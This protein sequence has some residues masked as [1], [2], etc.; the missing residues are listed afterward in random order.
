MSDPI[1][2]EDRIYLRIPETA[3][4]A[5]ISYMAMIVETNDGVVWV[6]HSPLY[7]DAGNKS[8]GSFW[9]EVVDMGTEE[10]APVGSG[11]DGGQ[12]DPSRGE[13]NLENGTP[14]EGGTAEHHL[15]FYND[16]E[17]SEFLVRYTIN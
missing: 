1:E 9:A 6:N 4:D 12:P 3:P 5:K 15:Q 2:P 16:Q 8:S 17:V 13:E 10:N 11:F 14:T 7:D